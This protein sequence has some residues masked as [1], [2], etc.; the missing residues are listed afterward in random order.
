MAYTF[1]ILSEFDLC[2]LVYSGRVELKDFDDVWAALAAIDDRSHQ[3]DAL[4]LLAPDADYS[5]MAPASTPDQS[6]RYVDRFR[7]APIASIK[8]S[9]FVCGSE[10][11]FTMSR[12]FSAFV[13]T[14]ILPNI[15]VNQFM[16]LRPALDWLDDGRD[17]SPLNREEI[18]SEIVRLGQEWCLRDKPP[19]FR[20]LRS[21]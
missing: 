20:S 5:H 1:K 4:V 16:S 14:R 8:H 6:D 2:I 18:S 11:L 17:A 19:G 21:S 13:D 9:A 10:L 3:Y 15:A 12:M 7:G